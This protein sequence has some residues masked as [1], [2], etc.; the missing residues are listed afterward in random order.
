MANGWKF[1]RVILFVFL[2]GAT[3]FAMNVPV[4]GVQDSSVKLESTMQI[5]DPQAALRNGIP[6]SKIVPRNILIA[7][8]GKGV[9]MAE[10]DGKVRY[11]SLDSN[12]SGFI[13]EHCR[14]V[15]LYPIIAAAQKEDG[16]LLVVSAG[17]YGGLP[18]SRNAEYITFC[19]NNFTKKTVNRFIQAMALDSLGKTLV[20]ADSTSG[21]NDIVAID[22]YTGKESRTSFQKMNRVEQTNFDLI[23]DVAVNIKGDWVI[24]AEC[25]GEVQLMSLSRTKDGIELLRKK[26]IKINDPIEKIYFSNNNELLYCNGKNKVKKIVIEDLNNE[27]QSGS[28]DVMSSESY[29]NVAIDQGGLCAAVYWNNGNKIETQRKNNQGVLEEFE[30]TFSVEKKYRYINDCGQLR[31]GIG[32]LLNVALRGE[33]VIALA[34]DGNMRLWSLPVD[35]TPID[36]T[37]EDF[38]EKLAELQATSG[39]LPR[40]KRGSS[41]DKRLAS[42]TPNLNSSSDIDRATRL[43]QSTPDILEVPNKQRSRSNSGVEKLNTTGDGLEK[44]KPSPRRVNELSKKSSA[45]NSRE[46]SL[47]PSVSRSNSAQSS[48]QHSPHRESSPHRE[49]TFEGDKIVIST[50]QEQK[51]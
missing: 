48:P 24:A 32:R 38:Y 41:A 21:W 37:R 27:N 45:P 20:I 43:V 5:F 31:L 9:L 4:I 49:V 22:L 17:N 30:A 51:I 2:Y 42:S 13:Y 39:F 33:Q 35:T 29:D 40:K 11:V 16:S 10:H 7:P 12:N 15:K 34:T 47:S 23:A 14:D 3:V 50:H 8:H 28:F 36:T 44:K 46:S 19:N 18:M 26:S 1:N 6:W 25:Q